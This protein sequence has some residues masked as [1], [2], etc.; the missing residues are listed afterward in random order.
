VGGLSA[1]L[2]LSES[3]FRLLVPGVF[4]SIDTCSKDTLG[5]MPVC[6]QFDD[7]AGVKAAVGIGS[8]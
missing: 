1:P 7:G 4:D 5:K 6:G 8:S 2:A 3:R